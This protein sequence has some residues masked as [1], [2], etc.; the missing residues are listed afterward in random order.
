LEK[1]ADILYL[2]LESVYKILFELE[3]LEN[4]LKAS[5]DHFSPLIGFTSKKLRESLES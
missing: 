3:E 5:G 4:T 1:F 2:K